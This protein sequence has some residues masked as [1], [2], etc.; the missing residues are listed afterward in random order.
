MFF[1]RTLKNVVTMVSVALCIPGIAAAQESKFVPIS[2]EM[3]QRLGISDPSLGSYFNNLFD[4]T[5]TFAAILAVL[6]IA[7]SGLEY[8]TTEAVS[9]KG[10]SKERIQQAILGLLMLL[11]TWLFFNEILG[12]DALQLDF[13]LGTV[14]TEVSALQEQRPTNQLIQPVTTRGTIVH[15]AEITGMLRCYPSE[16]RCE[17]ALTRNAI[18][19]ATCVAKKE[20]FRE[21]SNTKY[22]PN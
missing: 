9:G 13:N 4:L 1:S 7:V 21:D 10:N 15:C 17:A 16:Q 22:Y 20:A 3:M 6:V 14:A 12:K 5:L 18:R 8:M 19:N 2:G 11:G